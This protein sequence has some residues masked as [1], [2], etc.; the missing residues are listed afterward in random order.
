MR[1]ESGGGGDPLYK[2]TEATSDAQLNLFLRDFRRRP[3]DRRE[4]SQ[5]CRERGERGERRERKR[6]ERLR[7]ASKRWPARAK[8]EEFLPMFTAGQKSM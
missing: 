1:K 6:E 5:I 8:D 3:R 4:E 7:D 2:P